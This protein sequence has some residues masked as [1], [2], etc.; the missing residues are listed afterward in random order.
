MTVLETIANSRIKSFS[1]SK[2]F[3]LKLADVFEV[4]YNQLCNITALNPKIREWGEFDFDIF[5]IHIWELF[6][7]T[8][9]FLLHYELFEDINKLL[10]KALAI[11]ELPELFTDYMNSYEERIKDSHVSLIH[12]ANKKNLYIIRLYSNEYGLRWYL[13]EDWKRLRDSLK[14]NK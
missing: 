1:S 14:N 12:L 13:P 10:M 3:G 4:L 9:A 7:C 11:E 5:R 8:I 2:D 6:I